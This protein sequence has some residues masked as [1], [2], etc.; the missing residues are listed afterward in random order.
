[1]HENKEKLTRIGEAILTSARNDLYLSM[2]FL[3]IAL[4]GLG[5]Q[6]NLNTARVGTDGV[7]ILYNPTFLMKLY[8]EDLVLLNRYY[9][10]MV[11]HCMFR[12]ELN[13][14]D[15]DPDLWDMAC[16]IAA[17]N[18]LDGID[19]RAVNLMQSAF[20]EEMYDRL[21]EDAKVLTAEAV[22]RSLSRWHVSYEEQLRIRQEFFRDDHQ[23]WPKDPNQEQQEQEQDGDA[24]G[25]GDRRQ[26]EAQRQEI[27]GKWK[28]IDQKTQTNLETF[29]AEHGTEA[30]GLLKTI[31]V[32]NRERYDYARFLRR[33]VS[34]REEMKVDPDSFDYAFYAY[35][36]EL[37]GDIPL[38]E[39]L[40]YQESQKIQDFVIVIDT[41]D[42]CS[43][44]VIE[45][46]L[47]ETQTILHHQDAFFQHM[48]LHIIQADAAVQM[49]TVLHSP[50]EF[51]RFVDS[52]TVKGY[53]GTDF[54][55]AFAYVDRLLAQGQ[56][57]ELKGL[58]YFTDGFGDYP[59]RKPAYET[60][61][62]FFEDDYTDREVPPWAIKLVLGPEELHIL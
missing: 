10:H 34:L 33:F 19:N 18:V 62:V 11:L 17:E 38:I 24:S 41:S 1:M 22:Y 6:M 3:D 37:Y 47:G 15:R 39:P 48:N 60:A 16:D 49:D 56:L 5:Y 59:Q 53:G 27:E 29:F 4:S 52:F 12:H 54:R 28:H 30:E 46:F 58:L 21:H 14:G 40:E 36:L 42:S 20:R 9:L 61:F 44:G 51:D 43:D 32:E 50:A 57:R 55:P 8:Q 13:R 35:G 45:A 26:L 31:R 25:E 2:R 7:N 23:F